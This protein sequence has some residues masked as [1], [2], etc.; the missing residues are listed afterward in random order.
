LFL[1]SAAPFLRFAFEKVR[2]RRLEARATVDHCRATGALR[3]VGAVR[4]GRL[5][6]SF[7]A[8]ES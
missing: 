3:R 7:L 6:R 4:E 2:V 5:R 8:D 1:S